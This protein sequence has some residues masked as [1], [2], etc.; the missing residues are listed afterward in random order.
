MPIY[1]YR[2]DG[3]NHEFEER[4]RITADALVVC[5]ECNEPKLKKIITAGS[6][7]ILKGDGWY[8]TDF[9]NKS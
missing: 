6:S 4:Q 9:K 7:F 8:E 5:P 3:C 2:C 1:T